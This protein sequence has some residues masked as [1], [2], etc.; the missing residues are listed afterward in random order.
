MLRQSSRS[1]W[2]CSP[3][4]SPACS[5]PYS[6]QVPWQS[7]AQHLWVPTCGRRFS[8]SGDKPFRGLDWLSPSGFPGALSSNYTRH[9][10]VMKCSLSGVCLSQVQVLILSLSNHSLYAIYANMQHLLTGSSQGFIQVSMCKRPMPTHSRW[11]ITVG[12]T[13]LFPLL[14]T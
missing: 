12:P 11:S 13:A 4:L 10:E 14:L 5:C 3:S 1:C 9:R 7:P 2:V 8:A 6:P